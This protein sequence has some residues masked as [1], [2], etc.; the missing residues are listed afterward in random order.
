LDGNISRKIQSVGL[1][2]SRPGSARG[3]KSAF[4]TASVDGLLPQIIRN[5]LK[6]SWKSTT[7]GRKQK[8][9]T[10]RKHK[11]I[12]FNL[13]H[14]NQ[15]SWTMCFSGFFIFLTQIQSNPVQ[16]FWGSDWRFVPICDPTTL[17]GKMCRFWIHGMI[18]IFLLACLGV[19]SRSQASSDSSSR[20]FGRGGL[21][22]CP[23]PPPTNY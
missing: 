7:Y 18:F 11:V 14:R 19:F 22:S 4:V 12:H 23:S 13:H 5:Y 20:A 21:A 8:E 3:R 9:E 1:I 17:T 15:D 16:F 6:L 10:S 2:R